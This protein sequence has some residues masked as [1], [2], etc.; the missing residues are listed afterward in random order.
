MNTKNFMM[1]WLKDLFPICRSL[2]GRGTYETIRYLQRI[3]SNLKI[4]SF[5]SG[6]KVFD[7]VIPKELF[8]GIPLLVSLVK[9]NCYQ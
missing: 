2:T 7:W 5:N 6:K 4:I 9:R 3:N 8:F 1:L